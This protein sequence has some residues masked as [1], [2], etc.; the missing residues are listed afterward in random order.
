MS[1]ITRTPR[2]CA[3][4]APRI[5]EAA[6]QSMWVYYRDHK[7]QLVSHVREYRET[8]LV[9]LIAGV[10][11]ETAFAPHVKPAECAKSL[12]RAA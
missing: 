4:A 10:P 11:V 8:I 7:A 5:E 3:A 6:A 2:P 1:T 9:D 12:R